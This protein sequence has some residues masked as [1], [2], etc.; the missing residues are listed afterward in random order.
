MK[1]L[2]YRLIRV[3]M[4]SVRYFCLIKDVLCD[5]VQ[6]TK[7]SNVH[8]LCSFIHVF[9]YNSITKYCWQNFIKSLAKAFRKT[10]V[11]ATRKVSS[12]DTLHWNK[13]SKFWLLM[14]EHDFKSTHSDIYSYLLEVCGSTWVS[15]SALNKAGVILRR[16]SA[17]TDKFKLYTTKY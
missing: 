17:E 4:I 13:I 7:K 10:S 12:S 15:W 16:T 3:P 11:D 14:L 1:L 8:L 6:F 5:V 9:F 2:I